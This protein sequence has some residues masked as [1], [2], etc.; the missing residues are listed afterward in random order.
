[1]GSISAGEFI[2]QMVDK[3]YS[4]KRQNGLPRYAFDIDMLEHCPGLAAKMSVPAHASQVLSSQWQGPWNEC[5][6]P[7][8][9]LYIAEQGFR[10]DLHVDDGH[11]NFVASMCEGEK[12]WRITK[13]QDWSKNWKYLGVSP[14]EPGV[15]LDN[16]R[17]VLGD[18]PRPFETWNE[19]SDLHSLDIDVYE[20]VLRPGEMIYIPGGAPH[21][22]H[23]LNNSF[24]VAVNDLSVLELEEFL[25]ACRVVKK[26]RIRALRQVCKDLFKSRRKRLEN[27]RANWALHGNNVTQLTKSWMETF[28]CQEGFCHAVEAKW[29]NN[30]FECH[31]GKVIRKTRSEL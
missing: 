11:T 29:E 21:G 22:A 27:F 16:G 13:P 28:R 26:N 23:T 12:N 19:S 31:Q 24:M 4:A 25:E 15:M 1:M 9:N 18:L 10:T 2:A 17:F 3:A 14:E 8:F 6:L 30:M 7:E 5:Q 20:G